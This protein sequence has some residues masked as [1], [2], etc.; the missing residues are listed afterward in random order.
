MASLGAS[1]DYLRNNQIKKK[2]LC[3]VDN[4]LQFIEKI[5]ISNNSINLKKSAYAIEKKLKKI[6]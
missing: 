4:S 5:E 3:D 2:V 6:V 1:V